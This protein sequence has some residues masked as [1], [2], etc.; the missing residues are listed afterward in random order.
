MKILGGSQDGVI[1]EIERE[2][3][4]SLQ[5]LLDL[6]DGRGKGANWLELA[7][8]LHD[9]RRGLRDGGI[10][11][12]VDSRCNIRITHD[13]KIAFEGHSEDDS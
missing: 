11:E 10:E 5:G 2:L 3:L 6:L 4:E 9:L 13:V 12:H 7:W 1:V 8:F